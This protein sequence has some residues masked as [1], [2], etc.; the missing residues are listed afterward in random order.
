MLYDIREVRQRGR[1]QAP[2]LG[3]FDWRRTISVSC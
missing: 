2:P 1:L 3:Q